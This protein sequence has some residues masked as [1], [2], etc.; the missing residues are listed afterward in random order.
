M[1]RQCLPRTIA[2]TRR[3]RSGFT[4]IE[5]VVALT[6]LSILAAAAIPYAELTITRSKELELRRSLREVRTAIDRLHEDWETG[7]IS[8]LGGG[9]SDDGY[10]RT[11][12][13]LL[14]GAES[15]DAK[16]GKR[17]YLRRIPEDPYGEPGKPP[18]EQWAM[19]G[20]QDEPDGLSWNGRDVYDV[21][22]R[23]DRTAIDGT[24]YRDW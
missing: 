12:Q 1:I 16:G 17:K 14:E 18:A 11:L 4:L 21:R 3:A 20:Y 5:L 23:S 24:R 2:D 7:K 10:P 9:I 6:I 13:V 22:S 15:G 19:R 8:K